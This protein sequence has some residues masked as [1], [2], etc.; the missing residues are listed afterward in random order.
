MKFREKLQHFMQGRYGNDDLNKF[1]IYTALFF[2]VISLFTGNGFCNSIGLIFLI[3][4][5]IRMFSRNIYKRYEENQK[6]LQLKYKVFNAIHFD[7][8]KQMKHYRFFKCP[9]CRQTVRVP[10]GKGKIKIHCPKCQND[11]IKKS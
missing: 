6:F 9:V 5:Y 4:T 8:I 2:C 10:K 3:L 7:R 11:F 1:L